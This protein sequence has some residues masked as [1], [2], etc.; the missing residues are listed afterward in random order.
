MRS[1]WGNPSE[2]TTSNSE[3]SK[4]LISRFNAIGLDGQI[5]AE[6]ITMLVDLYPRSVGDRSAAINEFLSDS[7]GASSIKSEQERVKFVNETVDFVTRKLNGA[8]PASLPPPP[9]TQVVSQPQTAVPKKGFKKG[10]KLSGNALKEVVGNVKPSFVQRYSDDEGDSSAQQSRPVITSYPMERQT[11][12][13]SL[14]SIDRTSFP[15]LSRGITN[16]VTE[17]STPTA[18]PPKLKPS[19]SRRKNR[20]REIGPDEEW[21]DE[22]AP[23][24]WKTPMGGDA[25]SLMMT[26]MESPSVETSSSPERA[27]VIPSPIIEAEP[28]VPL[29]K[30]PPQ[31]VVSI[32]DTTPPPPTTSTILD[33][34]LLPT[35]ILSF[36]FK[37]EG[38]EEPSVSN[39]HDDEVVSPEPFDLLKQMFSQSGFITTASNSESSVPE[40]PLGLERRTQEDKLDVPNR[41]YT[42]SYM[43]NVLKE[44]KRRTAGEVPI[45]DKLKSLVF[46][47]P[48]LKPHWRNASQIDESQTHGNWR[49]SGYHQR[50]SKTGGSHSGSQ[51]RRH[52]PNKEEGFW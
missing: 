32:L 40:I 8:V 7:I 12:Q 19:T 46:E 33:T 1:V 34:L 25:S 44:M 4:S 6:Y 27:I 43:L 10:I 18:A 20:A 36:D 3:L 42:T 26:P 45:P 48:V 47:E 17:S 14:V 50:W 29:V 21:E 52:S 37:F 51:S 31:E 11:S 16:E 39:V 22:V 28:V 49:S 23:T 13:R 5:C 24:P 38:E 2:P 30:K 35:D 15:T 41:V 9:P